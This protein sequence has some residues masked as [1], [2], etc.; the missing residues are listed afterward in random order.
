MTQ[1][2]K[3][4]IWGCTLKEL[5]SDQ[6][7]AAAQVAVEHN[8]ANHPDA[9]I[10]AA[11]AAVAG[12][13]RP[14]ADSIA[15]LTSKYWGTSGVDLTV[16]FLDNPPRDLRAKILAHMN[17]W[18]KTAN[19]TFREEAEGMRDRAHVRI[20]RGRTGHW[21][22]LGTD[23][24]LI[25]AGDATMNLQEFT[26]QTADSEF[27]RVVRHETGHTLGCPHE[28]LRKELVDL[29]DEKKAIQYFGR[30]QGWSA[31]QVR[32]QVLT[33]IDQASIQA[34]AE[35]QQSIMCYQIPGS[36]T[37]T[38]KPIAGGLDIDQIDY[39]FMAMMYPKPV[40]AAPAPPAAPPPAPAPAPPP[41]PP[42]AAPPPPQPGPHAPA[43][44]EASAS[45][46]AKDAAKAVVELVRGDVKIRL[47]EP[48]DRELLKDLLRS[49][50]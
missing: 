43:A 20:S 6:L 2:A 18:S 5:P 9:N 41:A 22:Y 12:A 45:D 25:T 36:L 8:L 14:Q 4:D 37:K 39:D 17:A 33:P 32:R 47:L 49:I 19:I 48:V 44:G 11:F 24:R 29:I 31:D 10:I 38:G 16:G 13:K 50:G 46:D 28:H 34:T 7:L 23:I 40:S 3:P 1:N 30:T 42:P 21:S 15:M 26:M 27:F 35:D